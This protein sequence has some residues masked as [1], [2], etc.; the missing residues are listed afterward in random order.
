MV[1]IGGDSS[2]TRHTVERS[3]GSKPLRFNVELLDQ[4]EPGLVGIAPQATTSAEKL[5]TGACKHGWVDEPSIDELGAVVSGHREQRD[6]EIGE[7][8][9]LAPSAV[10]VVVDH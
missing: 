9:D 6:E 4:P 5:Q 3:R 8:G 2:V 7:V 10:V 1:L